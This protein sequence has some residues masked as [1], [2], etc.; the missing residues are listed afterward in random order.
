MSK[1]ASN[2]FVKAT[3]T[4]EMGKAVEGERQVVKTSP[5]AKKTRTVCPHRARF[6]NWGETP[7]IHVE[8]KLVATTPDAKR[9]DRYVLPA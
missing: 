3:K 8:V 7:T 5:T 9:R 1:S 2:G 4:H 6:G